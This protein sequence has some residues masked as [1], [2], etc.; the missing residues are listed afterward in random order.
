ML[1]LLDYQGGYERNIEIQ[2]DVD[3]SED[4]ITGI[5]R[6]IFGMH[7]SKPHPM[8]YRRPIDAEAILDNQ[9]ELVLSLLMAKGIKDEEIAIGFIDEARPQDTANTAKVWRFEKVR[10]MK[11]A[12]KFNTNIIGFHAINGNSVNKFL[13]NS[14]APS[15]AGFLES[16]KDSNKAYQAIVV[17]IDNLPSHKSK[18]VR[19]KA[20]ELDIYLAYMPPYSLDLTPIEFIWKSIERVR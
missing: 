15:I 8:D 10:C 14:K 18:L 20:K 19:Q 2:F 3:L 7:F 5:L 12:T 16:M 6:D 9:L 17:I 1:R 13:E 4:Q 11:N